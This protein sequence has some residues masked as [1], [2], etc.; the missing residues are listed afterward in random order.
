MAS[1]DAGHLRAKVPPDSEFFGIV[2][3]AYRVFASPKPNATDVCDCC[4]APAIEADFFDNPIARLPL[5][6]IQDWY[7]AAYKTSGVTKETWAYLL[8][9]ILE[10]L[11][12]AEDVSQTALEVSLSR[13]DTGNPGNWS[14][15]QWRVLD[16]FQ[17]QYMLHSLDHG[18]ACLDDVLCMFR[19]GGWPLQ[20]LLDQ[21][22]AASDATLARRFWL[23]WA[24]ERAPGCESIWITA[25]WEGNDGSIVFDFYT[26]P[27]MF[28]RMETLA[29]TDGTD[30]TL[31][32]KALEV[33][34]IIS[35]HRK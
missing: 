16:R 33:A 6:Y 10:I 4:M 29:L 3:E 27:R 34:S 17:R 7:F 5:H 24:N 31:A 23:D 12:A 19:L 21:V 1:E 22:A 18:A 15:H 14:P 35:R 28:E 20:D 25:F 13:F 26:S 8:P 2:E 9:R 32:L 30:V 11:A